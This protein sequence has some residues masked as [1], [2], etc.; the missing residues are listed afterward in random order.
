M[1]QD[2]QASE[3]DK[4]LRRALLDNLPLEHRAAADYA[5]TL[6]LISADTP[7]PR[8]GGAR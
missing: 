4:R 6:A 1:A 8:S 3:R 2:R 7:Q 5:F